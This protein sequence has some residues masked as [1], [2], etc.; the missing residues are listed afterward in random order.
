[1]T[2]IHEHYKQTNFDR[3]LTIKLDDFILDHK[4]KNVQVVCNKFLDKFPEYC[5]ERN[6]VYHVACQILETHKEEQWEHHLKKDLHRF[7]KSTKD[8]SV[9]DILKAFIK[10]YDKYK[11]DPAK[12]YQQICEIL[13]IKSE[14]DTNDR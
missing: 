2:E 14:S 3:I 13:D 1:M 6:E 5:N 7:I 10:K 9:D 11:S 4:F 8:L 12:I